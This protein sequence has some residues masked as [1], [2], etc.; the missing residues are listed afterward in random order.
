MSESANPLARCNSGNSYYGR[1]TD[2]PS[3][4]QLSYLRSLLSRVPFQTGQSAQIR[5]FGHRPGTGSHCPPEPNYANRT[6]ASTSLCISLL[7]SPGLTTPTP[8][9]PGR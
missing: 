5:A 1:P 4:R 3:E 9:S 2:E 6:K 7:L 8:L